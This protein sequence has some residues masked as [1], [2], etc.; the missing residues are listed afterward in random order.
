MDTS[1]LWLLKDLVTCSKW[2]LDYW[3]PW[4]YC[5]LAEFCS[6]WSVK[7][8]TMYKHNGTH[9]PGDLQSQLAC[10]HRTSMEMV[11]SLL[12]VWWQELI[13][14]D[15]K[16]EEEETG[17]VEKQTT[18]RTTESRKLKR[19]SRSPDVSPRRKDSSK[20][21]E[22]SDKSSSKRK[23]QKNG[24]RSDEKGRSKKKM[25]KSKSKKKKKK[26]PAPSDDSEKNSEP[27]EGEITESEREEWE[28][29]PS[30]SSSCSSTSK[31]SPESEME[32][33]NQEGEKKTSWI[34]SLFRAHVFTISACIH[35]FCLVLTS[36]H[37]H[38]SLVS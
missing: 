37:Y 11:I 10:C 18:K 4:E 9:G 34:Q 12:T 25:K 30:S 28:S 3:F 24:S 31:D 8:E 22:E 33:Q 16:L 5:N 38:L 23:K 36:S 7:T 19:K 29:T 17:W 32:T 2:N 15:V 35:L 6:D 1:D 14:D 26:S 27:E 13:F 20:H 21:R